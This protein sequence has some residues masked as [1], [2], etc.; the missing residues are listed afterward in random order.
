MN[1]DVVKVALQGVNQAVDAIPWGE[2]EQFNKDIPEK[3]RYRADN[4][5]YIAKAIRSLR[6]LESALKAI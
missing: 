2:I 6:V 1:A 3:D 5:L 4:S